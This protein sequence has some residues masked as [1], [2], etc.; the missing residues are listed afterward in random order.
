MITQEAGYKSKNFNSNMHTQSLL[1]QQTVQDHTNDE[2]KQLGYNLKSQQF[3]KS[4]KSSVS[5]G[6]VNSK[7][8][9]K[10]TSV[11]RSRLDF[12]RKDQPLVYENIGQEHSQ[13]YTEHT[14]E[15]QDEEDA[16][17]DISKIKIHQRL[18]MLKKQNEIVNQNNNL[19]QIL[20][21]RIN[22]LNLMQKQDMSSLE[23]QNNSSW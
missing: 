4:F 19:S 18:Q 15:V 5:G 14:D 10:K 11:L 16:K 12:K 6:N 22:S 2:F 3:L 17:T 21:N 23:S 13:E 7:F 8:L 20:Q 1:Q 9:R